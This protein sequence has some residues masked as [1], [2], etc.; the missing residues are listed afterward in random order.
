[1]D[2]KTLKDVANVFPSYYLEYLEN[3]SPSIEDEEYYD[4]LIDVVDNNSEYSMSYYIE[5]LN[6]PIDKR[7]GYYVKNMLKEFPQRYYDDSKI[8]W[9]YTEIPDNI[10]L[11]YKKPF[12]NKVLIHR[13]YIDG[14]AENILLNG[15]KYGQN[16]NN[17][18]WSCGNKN[19]EDYAFAYDFNDYVEN[20]KNYLTYGAEGVVFVGSGVMVKHYGDR[21][22]KYDDPPTECIFDKNSV[23]S[24]ICRFRLSCGRCEIY[25]SKNKL[26]L[27]KRDYNVHKMLEWISNNLIKY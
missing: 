19:D 8:Y 12:I 2:V 15:F 25:N 22:G 7:F 17:L 13:C 27:K 10:T 21:R 11:D 24:I 20:C 14:D 4:D 18:A 1:M 6:L 5:K 23:S 26:V 3:I 16:L 9:K